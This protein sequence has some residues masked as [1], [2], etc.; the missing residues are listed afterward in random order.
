MYAANSQAD[1]AQKG[2]FLG[3]GG[4][5]LGGLVGGPQGAL[6]GSSIGGAAAGNPQQPQQSQFTVGQANNM[7]PSGINKENSFYPPGYTYRGFR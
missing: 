7:Y 5:A 2:M 1:Q 3:L 4:A 6:I